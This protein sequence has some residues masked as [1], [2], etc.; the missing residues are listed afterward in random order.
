MK[1]ISFVC[2][3]IVEYVLCIQFSVS[4]CAEKMAKD[5]IAIEKYYIA[6][7]SRRNAWEDVLDHSDY[8]LVITLIN[9]TDCW[10]KI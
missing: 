1:T 8:T 5:N 4:F 2:Y 3:L 7:L 6:A 9:Y 10:L